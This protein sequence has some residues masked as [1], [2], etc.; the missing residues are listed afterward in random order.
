[1]DPDPGFRQVKLADALARGRSV[2]AYDAYVTYGHNIGTGASPAPT[3]G[4]RWRSPVPPD[5]HGALPAGA[6]GRARGPVHD[7]DE[8][9]PAGDGRPR[10]PQLRHEGRAVRPIRRS[11]RSGGPSHG[12]GGRGTGRSPLRADPLRLA[13]GR[14]TRRH[15]ILRQLPRLP[16]G[17]RWRVQRRQGRVPRSAG[18]LV[19]RSRTRPTW[20]TGAR[21]SSR[22]TAWPTTFRRA[23]ACSRWPTQTRPRPRSRGSTPNP[24]ATRGPP[25]ASPRST[26]TRAWCCGG[27]STTWASTTPRCG[28]EPNWPASTGTVVSTRPSGGRALPATPPSSSPRGWT[29]RPAVADRVYVG[30]ALVRIERW[31][32]VDVLTEFRRVLRPGGRI[33]AA[34]YDVEVAVD[35]WRTR[36][37]RLLLGSGRGA[38][39]RVHRPGPR[40]RHGPE[41]VHRPVARR[42][43]RGSRFCRRPRPGTGGDGGSRASPR[44]P[45]RVRRPLL[46]RRGSQPGRLAPVVADRRAGRRPPRLGRPGRASLRRRVDGAAS[47]EVLADLPPGRPGTLGRHGRGDRGPARRCRRS[48]GPSGPDGGADARPDLRVPHRAVRRR[49][50]LR[51]DPRG[52]SR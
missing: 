50:L 51:V 42:R 20:P 19:Q 41:P 16:A 27:S 24:S 49:H 13:A 21:S 25:A 37:P 39:C 26:S 10:G 36:R 7:G 6:A 3:A 29:S 11:A 12:G 9:D 14:R 46:F 15:P 38:R 47:A 32:V 48:G 43:P 18:R 31:E 45:R 34:V 23:R 8:L 4:V 40:S 52:A 30:P 44:R 35:A 5:R 2:P 22:K 1:M 28:D 33:R 17:I